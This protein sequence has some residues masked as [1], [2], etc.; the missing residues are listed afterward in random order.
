MGLKTSSHQLQIRA[1]FL[2]PFKAVY[3]ATHHLLLIARKKF[4]NCHSPTFR[5][6]L[7]FLCPGF[8]PPR[9]K[10]ETDMGALEAFE[11]PPWQLS[12]YLI[13]EFTSA[14]PNLIIV[15]SVVILH[16]LSFAAISYVGFSTLWRH[17]HMLTSQPHPGDLQQLRLFQKSFNLSCL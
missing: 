4:K 6:T 14:Q 10:T 13:Y 16:F 1:R 7:K 17:Q 12:S 3:G 2:D 5:V 8:F 9:C 15:R 11:S